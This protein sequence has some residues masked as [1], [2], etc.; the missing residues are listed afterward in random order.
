M[1][2]WLPVYPAPPR[3][4]PRRVVD[5]KEQ[6][7]QLVGAALAA[8]LAQ[9]SAD[10]VVAALARALQANRAPRVKCAVMEFF[11][12]AAPALLPLLVGSALGALLRGVLQLAVDKHPDI[13][14][15]AADAV[16]SAYLCSSCD[17]GG[18]ANGAQAVLAAMQ[19]LPPADLLGVQRAI[20]PTIQQR[21]QEA[22]GSQLDQQAVAPARSQQHPGSLS[23][24]QKNSDGVRPIAQQQQ[25]L[26]SEQTEGAMTSRS[27]LSSAGHVA[28]PSPAAELL[29]PQ[30]QQ[31][32]PAPPSPFVLQLPASPLPPPP[33]G[34]EQRSLDLA[35]A[36]QQQQLPSV[37]QGTSGFAAAGSRGE[38]PLLPFSDEA[39]GQ[40]H[41][42][43]VQLQGGPSCEALQGLSRLASAVPAPIW[44]SCFDQ[45]SEWGRGGQSALRCPDDTIAG[46]NVPLA[47][48]RSRPDILPLLPRHADHG[49]CLLRLGQLLPHC[50]AGVSNH[51]GS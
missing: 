30:P 31:F 15:A 13:R 50:A 22:A 17:G 44:V 34:A 6:I 28:S 33:A 46:R 20:G 43:L 1:L 2:T 48:S 4:D 16:A 41:R 40:L 51:S 23:S 36:A 8:A 14:R 38:G 11:A 39:A 49:S 3:S 35:L 37:R 45:V 10:A 32:T 7:R 5:P 21:S 42:L 27:Q 18:G 29:Q 24:S 26:S 25:H 19:C 9:H 12:A 47:S